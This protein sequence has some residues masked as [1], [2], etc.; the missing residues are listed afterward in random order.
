VLKERRILRAE[1]ALGED[2][3]VARVPGGL[4]GLRGINGS[5][6]ASPNLV[7]RGT[8]S[9]RGPAAEPLCL[10][11]LFEA[12]LHLVLRLQKAEINLWE[13]WSPI[14]IIM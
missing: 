8:K 10:G 5:A 13:Q 12:K 7:E 14:S 4:C 9:I 2:G 1:A 6:Q 3:V 11:G